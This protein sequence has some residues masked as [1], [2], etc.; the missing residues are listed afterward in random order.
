MLKK[1]SNIKTK[2]LYNKIVNFCIKDGNKVKASK[3][4]SLAFL[5]VSKK[6]GLSFDEI[7]S[8]LFIRLNSFVEIKKVRVRRGFH[9]VPFP[10]SHKRS[11]YLIIKWLVQAIKEDTRKL[12]MSEKL[13]TEI[14]GTIVNQSSK[15]LEIKNLNVSQVLAN[16][17]NVH[18]RW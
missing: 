3:I 17:A 9:M 13:A 10:I 11:T 18:F 12:P 1:Y 15:S 8:K 5:K 6:T 16:R 14:H 4:V 7:S 2:N